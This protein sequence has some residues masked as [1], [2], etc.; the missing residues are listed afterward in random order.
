M[1]K[2]KMETPDMALFEKIVKSVIISGSEISLWLTNGVIL[3]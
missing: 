2:L 1:D 3:S